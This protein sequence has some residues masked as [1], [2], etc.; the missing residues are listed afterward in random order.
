MTRGVSSLAAIGLLCAALSGCSSAPARFYTLT[1]VA[2]E[3]AAPVPVSVA[4]GPV[5]IPVVVDSATVVVSAGPNEVRPDD[6]NRWASPLQDNIARVVAANL[7]ALLGTGRVAL[8]S[9]ALLADPDYRVT[10]EVQRF[11]SVPGQAAAL[12]AV[13]SVRRAA[14]GAARVGR[15]TVREGVQRSDFGALAAAHSRALA[16]L[17]ED[18]AGAVRGL[19]TPGP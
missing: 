5:S 4:V 1:A 7:V 2:S 19:I 15:T 17:S 3:T 8:A 12:E 13:W 9:D 11:E 10:I 6:F 18:L 14:D 16:R